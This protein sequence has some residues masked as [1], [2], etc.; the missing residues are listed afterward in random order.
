LKAKKGSKATSTNPLNRTFGDEAQEWAKHNDLTW[1]EREQ[2]KL[3]RSKPLGKEGKKRVAVTTGDGNGDIGQ[4]IVGA[5]DEGKDDKSKGDGGTEAIGVSGK[6]KVG[7]LGEGPA[8]A[9]RRKK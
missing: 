4:G 5:I 7:D 2:E 9:K 8:H 1:T 3:R 6:A